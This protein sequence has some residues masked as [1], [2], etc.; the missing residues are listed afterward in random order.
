MANP[1]GMET[2]RR[3]L[4]EQAYE[5]IR[6][7]ILSLRLEP[8]R[9]VYENELATM[10]NMSRTP[11]REA[12]RTLLVE[13][14]IEVLPQRGMKVALISEKK[15]EEARFVRESL[16]VSALRAAIARWHTNAD[17][18]MRLRDE[19]QAALHAQ[20]KS[21]QTGDVLGF[22]EADERFHRLLMAAADNRTLVSIVAQMRAHLN[23]VR[24]LS[25]Q[26]LKNVQTLIEEHEQLVSVLAAGDEE[27]A[28]S[29]LTRHLR[30]LQQ[31]VAVVRSQYPLYFRD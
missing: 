21:A 19:V 18:G 2:D 30:R 31:D 1:F 20:R 27:R 14:L 17:W 28:V 29:L 3:S 10:L 24:T 9:A 22:L 23:R 11:V 5:A 13:E 12:V 26:E 4:S 8:G 16:E 25:L 7:A 6:E 15:V